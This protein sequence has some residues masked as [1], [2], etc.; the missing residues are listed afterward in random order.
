MTGVNEFLKQWNFNLNSLLVYADD[1]DTAVVV[2]NHRHWISR[3][4]GVNLLMA[5]S[6]NAHRIF[7]NTYLVP[8][9][10]FIVEFSR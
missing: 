5:E 4:S 2:F 9:V 7:L 6:S 10:S 1:Y 3:M 8:L